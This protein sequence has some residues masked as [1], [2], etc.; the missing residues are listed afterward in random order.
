ME[1]GL[2][3]VTAEAASTKDLMIYSRALIA[4]QKLDRIVV[5]DCHLAVTAASD[6][7]S[8]V[9][10]TL[11]R[12]L[13][14]Q[15]VYLTATL[16]PSMYAESEERNCLVHPK[17]IRAF[18]NWPILLYMVRKIKTGNGSLL[19]QAAAEA[20]DAWTCSHLFD[21]SHDKIILYVRGRNEAN[22]LA[23]LLDCAVYTAR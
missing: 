9:D 6:R 16:P 1:S 21:A 10:L 11:I 20:Q 3:L 7:E 18:S 22:E 17:V 12:R 14:T 13:R 19:E 5:D 23:S 15:F 2:V 8:I 4:Q